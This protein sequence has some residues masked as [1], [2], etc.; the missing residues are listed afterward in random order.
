MVFYI[1]QN[2]KCIIALCGILIEGVIE[3]AN[4][5]AKGV[6]KSIAKR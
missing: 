3:G 2:A 5:I 6:A 4:G 1:L